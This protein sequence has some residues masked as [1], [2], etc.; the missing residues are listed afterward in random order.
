[1]GQLLLKIGKMCRCPV[2]L[3]V[4]FLP[5]T[6]NAQYGFVEFGYQ[7]LHSYKDKALN[8]NFLG[9]QLGRG[10]NKNTIVCLGVYS[11][12]QKLGDKGDSYLSSVSGKQETLNSTLMSRMHVFNLNVSTPVLLLPMGNYEHFL[13]TGLGIQGIHTMN[14]ISFRSSEVSDD[15][16]ENEAWTVHQAYRMGKRFTLGCALSAN[17]CF[18]LLKFPGKEMTPYFVIGYSLGMG[19]LDQQA[20]YSY[21]DDASQANAEVQEKK[22]KKTYYFQEGTLSNPVYGF[23][24]VGLLW[25][26]APQNLFKAA[27]DTE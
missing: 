2:F 1:M 19:G 9:I 4:V 27:K 26:V 18:S 5:Y 20:R 16:D 7:H 3:L 15:P 12:S 13:E 6:G 24:T 8:M 22:S 23:I 11:G 17:V 21:T 10:V 14:K 25:R